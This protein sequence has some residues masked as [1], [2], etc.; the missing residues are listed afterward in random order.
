MIEV[1]GGR[2]RRRK[3]LL[4]DLKA[5]RGYW[6]LRSEALDY[7]VWRTCFES[8][9]GPLLILRNELMNFKGE[10]SCAK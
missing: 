3:Q 6:K 1:T 5:T 8:V 9:Y 2:G 7:F 4:Y 10:C